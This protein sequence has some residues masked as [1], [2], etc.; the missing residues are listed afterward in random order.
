MEGYRPGI[1]QAMKKYYATPGEKER[2]EEETLISP[3][4]SPEETKA[5]VRPA[6]G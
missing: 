1:E 5:E 4:K 2:R 6:M 3:P